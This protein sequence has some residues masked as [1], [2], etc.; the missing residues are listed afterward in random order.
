MAIILM[1]LPGWAQAGNV[2]VLALGDSLTAGYGLP[3]GS[4]LVPQLQNWLAARGETAEVINGGVSGDTTAG[5]AARLGWL[6][7]GGDVDALMVTLGGNDV[8]RGIAPEV[9]RANLDAI[10]REARDRDLP[11]LLV[12]LA[13][14]RNY[15]AAYKRNFDAIYPELAKTHGAALV[16]N[17]FQPLDD[18][19]G[20]P[21][22]YLRFMQADGIHPNAEGVLRI[23]AALGPHVAD[24]ARRAG[25]R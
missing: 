20:D 6:L 1:I 16:R 25:A 23:V 14:S 19:S 10:L 21:A 5:G 3:P 18:G 7:A 12:G 2:R 13:V 8:L 9:A 24:L 17:F 4:G 15:G 22:A 11:V